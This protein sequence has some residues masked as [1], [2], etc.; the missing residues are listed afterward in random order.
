MTDED[1]AAQIVR[2]QAKR[3]GGGW[4]MEHGVM[5]VVVLTTVEAE[6]LIK[7]LD[8]MPIAIQVPCKGETLTF[9]WHDVTLCYLEGDPRE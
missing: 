9:P 1:K 4:R 5:P 2:G 8:R 3:L 7:L 6:R